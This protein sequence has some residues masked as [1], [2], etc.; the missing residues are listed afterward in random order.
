MVRTKGREQSGGAG[1]RAAEGVTRMAESVTTPVLWCAVRDKHVRKVKRLLDAPPGSA[2]AASFNINETGGVDECTSLHCAVLVKD[3]GMIRLLLAYPGIDLNVPNRV[4]ESVLFGCVAVCH[5]VDDIAI[6]K[7]LVQ[8]G[9]CIDATCGSGDTLMHAAAFEGNRT[10]LQAFMDLGLSVMEHN[11]FYDTPLHHTT[12]FDTVVWL[13]DAGASGSA[14]NDSGDTALH[15]A[16]DHGTESIRVVEFLL[17]RGADVN[18]KNINGFTPLHLALNLDMVRFLLD[19]GSYVNAQTNNGDTILHRMICGDEDLELISLVLASGADVNAKNITGCTPLYFAKDIPMFSILLDAGACVNAQANN[20]NTVLH[21]VVYGKEDFIL[22]DLLFEWGVDVNIKND[23]GETALHCACDP[24]Y[25]PQ[26]VR[27][28]L[29]AG[30]QCN[31][32]N[33]DGY[34]P[35]HKACYNGMEHSAV[36][37]LQWGVDASE[38]TNTGLTPADLAMLGHHDDLAA[39][40]NMEVERTER[41]IAFGMAGQQRLGADSAA[42]GL[43]RVKEVFRMIGDA[44]FLGANMADM[45]IEL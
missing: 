21:R 31:V 37:F 8:H 12:D 3:L 14:P 38:R 41:L 39:A 23:Q 28:L 10:A 7:N 11:K 13:V 29:N 24:E 25:T 19:S 20:G 44:G 9:A 2:A 33:N 34:T 35:L 32:R 1:G 42:G 26:V 6:I 45:V 36:T 40:M 27:V 17:A 30:A 5:H 43:F 22:F 15:Y 4:G 16:V 18:V